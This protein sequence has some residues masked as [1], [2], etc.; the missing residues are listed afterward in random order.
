MINFN[1]ICLDSIRQTIIQSTVEWAC[2]RVPVFLP[3]LAVLYRQRAWWRCETEYHSVSVSLSQAA[4]TVSPG[5]SNAKSSTGTWDGWMDPWITCPV[6]TLHNHTTL[7][8]LSYQT[9]SQL[10]SN[11]PGESLQWILF[12]VIETFSVLDFTFSFI[13]IK[14][15]GFMS[16]NC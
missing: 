4:T 5:H 7:I 9:H 1:K 10:S 16:R 8:T 6:V 15:S 3:P 13:N 12:V 14:H 11:I 2:V